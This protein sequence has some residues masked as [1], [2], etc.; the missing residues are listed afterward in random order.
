MSAK[1]AR[2]SEKK[3]ARAIDA[4]DCRS[5]NEVKTNFVVGEAWENGGEERGEQ[6]VKE[7]QKCKIRK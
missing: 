6:R 4:E 5:K 2:H 7:R 1:R 3:R